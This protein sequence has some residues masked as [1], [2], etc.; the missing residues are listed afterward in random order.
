M[1]EEKKSARRERECRRKSVLRKGE[2][3]VIG[4]ECGYRGRGR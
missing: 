3:V 4:I 1:M 2:I